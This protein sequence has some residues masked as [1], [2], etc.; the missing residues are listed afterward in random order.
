MKAGQVWSQVNSLEV[1]SEF[2]PAGILLDAAAVPNAAEIEAGS[3]ALAVTGPVAALTAAAREQS[4]APVPHQE[5]MPDCFDLVPL[6]APA[7]LLVSEDVVLDSIWL[8]RTGTIGLVALGVAGGLVGAEVRQRYA[9][10]DEERLGL[11]RGL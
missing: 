1:A 3:P 10:K 4:D 8:Q 6:P 11:R 5:Y 7:A 2:T 9:A